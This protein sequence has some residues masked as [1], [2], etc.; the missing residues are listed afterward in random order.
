MQSIQ[1]ANIKKNTYVLLRADLNVPLISGKVRDD[2]RIS[3]IIPT[4]AYLQKK[5]ARTIVISHLGEKGESLAPV[6]KHLAKK[7]SAV[8][9]VPHIF[10]EAVLSA[11]EA[12]KPGDI[13]ILE[14]LRTDDGEKNNDKLFAKTLAGLG[15]VF[16]SDAFSASHRKHAS[17]VGI[18]KY[19][20]SYAGLQ[21]FEEIEQLSKC[22][23]PK[24][25]F[26]FILGGA[27]ISTKLPLL[28]TYKNKADTLFVSGAVANDFFK[29]KGYETGTSLVDDTTVPKSVLGAKTIHIPL[30]IITSDREVKLPNK[31]NKRDRILDA[32]PATVAQICSAIGQAKMVLLNGPLGDYENGFAAGTEVVLKAM[33]ASKALTIVGGG[34]SVATVQKL[35][36]EDKLTFVSTGG[37]AMLEYLAKGTLPGIQALGE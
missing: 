32:G 23:K 3:K 20:P 15:E 26:V 5:G 34:D 17:I 8:T 16:V 31:V 37:G 27:K 6:A 1:K 33:A 7:I 11:R 18:P 24:H 13:L 4:L 2:F 14:N 12:M 9:F 22:L 19:I 28:S 25:P 10:G 29:A 35:K 21:L 30:D 36:L